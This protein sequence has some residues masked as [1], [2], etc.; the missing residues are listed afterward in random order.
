MGKQKNEIGYWMDDEKGLPCFN[1]IGKLPF[2]ASA[3]DGEKVKLPEDPWF[4]LG[5]Y[6][7]TLFTH[8]S[9]KFEIITGQRSWGRINQAAERNSGENRA[10]ISI[11]KKKCILIG[12][13]DTLEELIPFEKTFGCGVANYSYSQDNIEV[14]RK[15]SVKP[16][17]NPYDG[18]AA[19]LI[20]INISN[21][22]TNSHEVNYLEGVTANYEEIQFQ[23]KQNENS[24][25]VLYSKIISKHE[26]AVAIRARIESDDPLLYG[27]RNS[28]AVKDGFPPTLFIRAKSQNISLDAI[29]REVVFN[30]SGDLAPGES[31]TMEVV[32]G[33]ADRYSDKAITKMAN[34]LQTNK[35]AKYCSAFVDEWNDILPSFEKEKDQKLRQEMRWH[36]YCL[37]SMATYSRYYHETKIPQGTVYD[38]D[39]GVHASARDNF[40]HL[41][42]TIYYN[43]KLAKSGLKYMLERTTSFGEIR[44]IEK[45]NGYSDNERYFTSDQQLYFFRFLSEYLRV[46]KDYEILSCKVAPY[47]VAGE[48]KVA[49][50]SFVEK[51]F[52]F[53]RDTI[54]IGEHGLIRLMNSDWN[55]TIYYIEKVP[56]NNVFFDG[57]SHMNSAMA[58][59]IFQ[60]LI[61]ILEKASEEEALAK[62]SKKLQ[63]ICQ[64]MKI[65]RERILNAYLKDMG[66]RKFPRRMYFNH[67]AYGE[68]NM[69]LE[70]QGFTLSINELSLE[71]KKA[72][73]E[74]MQ[75]RVY[76]GEKLGAREQQVPEF[77]DE[78]YDKGSR[79]NGGF[80]WALNGP[81]IV[82]VN[83]FDKKEA[84]ELLK[85]MTFNNFAKEFPDY[86]SS[87]WSAA[88]NI[89]S[90]LIKWEGLPDQSDNYS[91]SPVYC[92]HP[93]AW[94][95][96]CYY[97]LYFDT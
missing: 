95:L 18:E 3:C 42:P 1:Y 19:F 61:P 75:S 66:E 82:G 5:N 81:V 31:Q 65:Y 2:S 34:D 60:E 84:K 48:R 7:M 54:G 63:R 46:T 11:D 14:R 50:I 40:Q 96:Y 9:G 41:L 26:N 62:Y 71:K 39:W 86:W 57:E 29:D 70:P 43:P 35:G 49:V 56:Y 89:E 30:W 33:F 93:H 22:D 67:K 51:C 83:S 88:D 36:A 24:G 4:I 44:L 13:K 73:Y 17:K 38:Y 76:K 72:L 53:L 79:E 47:P 90:S 59:S 20:Q 68:N 52:I 6:K 69:F 12:Q 85:K 91:D 92:A 16:S 10:E 23:T 78:S 64:S 32:I 27:D 55:D 87:Y 8:V 28:M 45:G 21:N 80:W 94:I 74:E 25:K 15:I 97:R 37:E 77:E 58:I